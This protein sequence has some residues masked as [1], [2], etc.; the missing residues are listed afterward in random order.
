MTAA[1]FFKKASQDAIQVKK[2]EGKKGGIRRILSAP[3]VNID[4]TDSE[5]IFTLGAPG[6]QRESFLIELEQELLTISAVKGMM[7]KE[8]VPHH[9]EYD[10]SG[11]E[12][13]FLLPD[14]ADSLMTTA[15]YRNGELHIYIPRSANAVKEM[16]KFSI[17][18]Y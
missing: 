4:E 8:S 12:R 9:Q 6:F 1:A 10:F 13:A 15:V 18:V 16:D 3:A 14:D 2:Q 17:Y 5:Y 7:R 11:W